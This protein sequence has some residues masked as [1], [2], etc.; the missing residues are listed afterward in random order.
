[1]AKAKLGSG[2]RFHNIEEQVARE[3]EKK[4]YSSKEAHQIGRKVAASA[5]RA[6]HGNAAM[7]RYSRHG[8]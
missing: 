4:G 1:M 8:R 2:S 7:A 6:A 5:G 3:Y